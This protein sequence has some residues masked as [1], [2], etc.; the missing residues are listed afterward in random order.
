MLKN[1]SNYG[2][3]NSRALSSGWE[4]GP[5]AGAEEQVENFNRDTEPLLDDVHKS[6]DVDQEGHAKNDSPFSMTKHDKL[7]TYV[8]TKHFW[9]VLA[10]GYDE[11]CILS[12]S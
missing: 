6:S 11:T 9:M 7:F 10:L 2:Q 12:L 5:V 3:H 1:D 8:R 4:H